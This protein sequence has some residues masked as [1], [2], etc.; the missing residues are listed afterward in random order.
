MYSLYL[1]FLSLSLRN[2]SNALEPFKD[3]KRSH[4]AVWDW[5]Q[6]VGSCQIFNKHK[7]VSAFIIDETI[8]QIG[9]QHFWL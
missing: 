4:V 2:T 9:S 7:R 3:Q 5:I 6:R 1:Y 8:I